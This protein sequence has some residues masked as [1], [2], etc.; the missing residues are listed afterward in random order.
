MSESLVEIVLEKQ[1]IFHIFCEKSRVEI[2]KLTVG[3]ISFLFVVFMGF[4][5][6]GDSY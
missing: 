5:S 3:V 6:S 2:K 4:W 1:E